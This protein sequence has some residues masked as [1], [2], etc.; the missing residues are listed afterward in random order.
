MT[1][2]RRVLRVD[3]E[4]ACANEI[5]VTAGGSTWARATLLLDAS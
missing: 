3:D 5:T 1:A 2:L 4:D